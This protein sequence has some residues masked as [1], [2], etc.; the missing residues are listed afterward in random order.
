MYKRQ[1][2]DVHLLFR[3][4]DF[5]LIF[6]PIYYLRPSFLSLLVATQIRG[7]IAGSSPP[8]P[9]RF[10]PCVFYREKT[11]PCLSSS[12]LVKLRL[13]T[14]RRLSAVASF[15]NFANNLTMVGF[16]LQINA[17]IY[18]SS[19]IQGYIVAINRPPG[20]PLGVLNT[21]NSMEYVIPTCHAWLVALDLTF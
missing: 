13:P 8:S 17:I 18:V 5:I 6:H 16:E 10:V 2:T 12:I 15:F 20:R 19:S 3:G 14:L 1:G 11:Q 9:V 21:I 4:L 7:H